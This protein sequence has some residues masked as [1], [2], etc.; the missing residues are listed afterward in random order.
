M[1]LWRSVGKVVAM[2]V[3]MARLAA[4]VCAIP[5]EVPESFSFL[6]RLI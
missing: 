6:S 2:C 5:I 3:S 4:A 1:W